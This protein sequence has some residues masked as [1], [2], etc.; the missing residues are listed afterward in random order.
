MAG[1][2]LWL[3]ECPPTGHPTHCTTHTWV[4]TQ[5]PALLPAIEALRGGDKGGPYTLASI[6]EVESAPSSPYTGGPAQAAG[7]GQAPWV[8]EVVL[9]EAQP[10]QGC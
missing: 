10:Q 2:Q 9:L 6:E 8:T 3:L 4:C 5:A 1:W 7:D